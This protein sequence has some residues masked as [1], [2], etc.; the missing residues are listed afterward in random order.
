MTER[1]LEKALPLNSSRPT[2]PRGRDA[3]IQTEIECRGW[4]TSCGEFYGQL[5]RIKLA[6]SKGW[7]PVERYTQALL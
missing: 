1:F 7:S 6:S 2:E 3:L 5:I 4:M